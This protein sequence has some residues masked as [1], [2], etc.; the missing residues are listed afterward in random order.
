MKK[1]FIIIGILLISCSSCR[2][3]LHNLDKTQIKN[4][5]ISKTLLKGEYKNGLLSGYDQYILT[6]EHDG[7]WFIE[8][9]DHDGISNRLFHHPDCP[10]ERE[11]END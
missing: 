6:I 11:R 3:H 10:K 1:I 2:K 7:H 5:I 9:L 8:K 4:P